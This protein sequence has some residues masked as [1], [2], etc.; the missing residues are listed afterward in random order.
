MAKNTYQLLTYS[1][2]RHIRGQNEGLDTILSA[3]S[4]WEF[5]RQSGQS[6]PLVLALTGPTGVGK[7]ETSFRLAEGALAKR[8][9]VGRSLKYRPNGLLT[10]RGEDYTDGSLPVVSIFLKSFMFLSSCFISSCIIRINPFLLFFRRASYTLSFF[11]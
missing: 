3:I 1:L 5:Q 10:L 11:T 6:E 7:S 4:A 2:A 9:K 8:S